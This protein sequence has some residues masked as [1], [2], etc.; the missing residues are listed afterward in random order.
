M[1]WLH[2]EQEQTTV[3]TKLARIYAVCLTK[4]YLTY[5]FFNLGYNYKPVYTRIADALADEN[6][7]LF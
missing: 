2:N 1:S 5:I 4:R 3:S 6:V 7:L